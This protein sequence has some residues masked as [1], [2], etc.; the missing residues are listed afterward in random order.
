MTNPGQP[1]EAASQ[2]RRERL[3]ELRRK[4]DSCIDEITGSRADRAAA[5]K[6]EF[7]AAWKELNA[8]VGDVTLH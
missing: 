5:A 6:K 1:Q 2:P 4:L 3:E 7:D 8:E